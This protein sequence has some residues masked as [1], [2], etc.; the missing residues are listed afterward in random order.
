MSDSSD[1]EQ[2]TQVAARLASDVGEDLKRMV[3][4][5]ASS[6]S[7]VYSIIWMTSAASRRTRLIGRRSARLSC[8]QSAI[9]P[10]VFVSGVLLVSHDFN[11]Q[12][13][14]EFQHNIR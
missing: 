12:R 5:V 14:Y 13:L 2:V 10:V 7:T 3:G 9:E 11:A 8:F 4:E 6:R 1:R